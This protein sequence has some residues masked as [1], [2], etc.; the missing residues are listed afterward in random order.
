MT[1]ALSRGGYERPESGYDMDNLYADAVGF[2]EAMGHGPVRTF[3][4]HR[5]AGGSQ[6]GAR[7]PVATL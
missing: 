4:R 1:L 5:R 6:R 7:E 2:I 3:G